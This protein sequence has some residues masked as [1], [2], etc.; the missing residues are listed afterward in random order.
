MIA[1]VMPDHIHMIL[2]LGLE[3]KGLSTEMRNWKYWTAKNLG[4][5]WQDGFFDHRLCDAESLSQKY[6]YIL[7]NPVR[8]GL[9][10]SPSD[11][12]WKIESED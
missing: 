8:A 6:E 9:V 4:I 1:L 5:H 7:D 3:S 10:E 12:K 2:R 11:W